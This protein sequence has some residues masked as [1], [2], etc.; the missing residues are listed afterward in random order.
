MRFHI[1]DCH[2]CDDKTNNETIFGGWL[3]VWKE[4]NENALTMFEHDKCIFKQ[5]HK[6]TSALKVPSGESIAI[7]KDDG[8]GIMVSGFQS[9]EFGLPQGS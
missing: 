1:D 5:Y 2:L 4:S 7:P 9:Q 8:Q 3:S 6:T